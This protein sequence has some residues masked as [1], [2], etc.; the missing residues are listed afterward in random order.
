MI[1][2]GGRGPSNPGR[3]GLLGAAAA[4]VLA[5]LAAGAKD[6][7]PKRITWVLY[8]LNEEA[9]KRFGDP[10]DLYRGLLKARGLVEGRDF[11]LTFVALPTEERRECDELAERLIGSRPDIIAMHGH[12][13]LWSLRSRTRSI[14]VVFHDLGPDPSTTGLVES[15]RRPGTNFTGAFLDMREFVRKQLQLLKELVPSIRRAGNLF[16]RET[17]EHLEEIW[18]QVPG[19]KQYHEDEK[20]AVRSLLGIELV[21]VVVPGAASA[22]EIEAI[23]REARVQAV[24]PVPSRRVAET[25]RAATS[26]FPT[27]SM[28]F[29]DARAGSLIGIGRYPSEGASY[30]VEAVHRILRGEDPA[31]IPVYR[32]TRLSIAINRTTARK[33]GIE[34]PPSVLTLATEIYD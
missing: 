23:L 28:S 19:W 21:D 3:R 30:A 5:P 6:P 26:R 7:G 31:T 1:T 33:L 17:M 11:T 14:P 8:L 4:L 2:T 25:F 15:L 16:P 32:N 10:R 27:A 29:A 18:A 13:A 34:L 9:R 22:G 12:R 20:Q 24:L